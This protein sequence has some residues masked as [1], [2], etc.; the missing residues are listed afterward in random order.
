MPDTLPSDPNAPL[1]K[2]QQAAAFRA[3]AEI[4]SS[5]LSR[6]GGQIQEEFLIQLQG[7]QGRRVFEEMRLNDPVIAGMLFAM[8]MPLREVKWSFEPAG[9][10]PG[11]TEAAEFMDGVLDDMSVSWSDLISQIL[12]MLPFGWSLFEQVYKV[13]RGRQADPPS[14]FDD[15]KV[16]LRKLAFR[17]QSTLQ[18]WEIDPNGGIKGMVQ[19]APPDFKSVFIPIEKC[20]LFR[21]K[22]EKGNPEGRSILRTAYRPWYLK[23]T[24]ENLEAV[25]LERTGAG[26]PVVYLPAGWTQSDL[27]TAKALV[28]RIRVDE[29]YGITLPGPKGSAGTDGWLLEF[30]APPVS[31]GVGEGFHGAIVRYRQ[32]MLI[33]VLATFISLGSDGMGSYALSKNQR[34][35]FQVAIEGYARAIEDTFDRFVTPRLVAMN[36]WKVTDVPHLTHSDVGQVDLGTLSAFLGTAVGAGLITPDPALEDHLRDAAGLP[37]AEKA[38]MT[39]LT[40]LLN[41]GQ[42][43]GGTPTGSP[44]M[45]G[46]LAAEEQIV[47]QAKRA[48]RMARTPTQKVRAAQLVKSLEGMRRQARAGG[49]AWS[50][51]EAI[52]RD[53]A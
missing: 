46:S 39:L 17:S 7:P 16:G 50:D 13:R 1:S 33:S 44:S 20:V 8:E 43:G 5:G 49:A 22:S 21:T 27:A 28:R 19:M 25:A 15:G 35:F 32:E 14:K 38:D 53:M 11:D 30:L 23:K 41:G 6:S 2:A 9:D 3:S 52:S 4:G 24:L 12:T 37:D 29:Q 34:D 26:Y 42:S 48:A 47:Q 40:D 51:Y 36:G 45:D 18:R 31:R 10:K